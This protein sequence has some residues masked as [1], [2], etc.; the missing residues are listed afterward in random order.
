MNVIK[1]VLSMGA[2]IE[3]LK[4]F[5]PL[6]DVFYV[7]TYFFE[8]NFLPRSRL[9]CL[10]TVLMIHKYTDA[11]IGGLF[12]GKTALMWGVSQVRKAAILSSM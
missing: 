11:T 10:F 6:S 5:H 12:D 8:L 3:G 9:N 7:R 2:N 1:T 4:S